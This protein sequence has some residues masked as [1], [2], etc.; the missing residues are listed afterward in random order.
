MNTLSMGNKLKYKRTLLYAYI[1]KLH[2]AVFY[3][4][5]EFHNPGCASCAQHASKQPAVG[6]SAA[7]PPCAYA[8][9]LSLTKSAVRIGRLGS[10]IMRN[11]SAAD[12]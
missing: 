7:P 8:M 12:L 3:P 5:A 6:S 10:S 11:S 9:K 1:I 4:T 2:V